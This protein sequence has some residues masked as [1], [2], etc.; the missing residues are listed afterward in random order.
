MQMQSKMVVCRFNLLALVMLGLALVART[1]KADP[2]DGLTGEQIAARIVQGSAFDWDGA[3]TRMKMTLVAKDGGKRERAMEILAR[4]V[5]NRVQ[6]VVRFQNPPDVAGT[7]FLLLEQKDGATDQYIYLP[8]L[9]RTRRIVGREREG[10]F[11][12]SD[13]TYAELRRVDTT[14]AQHK[15]LADEKVGETPTAVVESTPKKDAKSPYAKVV[16]WVRSTDF[17]PMRT[18]FFDTKGQLLKTLYAR[19]IGKLEGKPVV[20]E[21]RMENAQTGSST[22]LVIDAIER[23]A[24]LPDSAFTPTA[25]EHR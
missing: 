10:S 22:L 21:A 12:G 15:R 1:S 24:S 4:R 13:F 7:A 23:Q 3:K 9:R 2:T 6:T 25:L 19:R 11:M 14:G 16:T 17:V 20:L 8:G 18:K 5:D